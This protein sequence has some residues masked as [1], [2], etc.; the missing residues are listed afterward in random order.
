MVEFPRALAGSTLEL[1]GNG[2]RDLATL[3][4]SPLLPS[5]HGY[6]MVVVEFAQV[7]RDEKKLTLGG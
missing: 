4:P 7:F 6:G 3:G 5:C 1:E 2:D